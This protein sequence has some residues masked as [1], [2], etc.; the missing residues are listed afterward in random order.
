MGEGVDD[1]RLLDHGSDRVPD[2]PLDEAELH[3]GEPKASAIS[4]IDCA[5]EEPRS[6][7]TK[8]SR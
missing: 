3:E 1:R 2:T 7:E 4:T 5:A 6:S 8:P